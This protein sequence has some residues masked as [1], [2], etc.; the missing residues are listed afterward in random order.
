MTNSYKVIFPPRAS[1][2]RA[3][4]EQKENVSDCRMN[5]G[6]HDAAPDREQSGNDYNAGFEG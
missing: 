1:R 5:Y 3:Y 4:R 2:K 6:C